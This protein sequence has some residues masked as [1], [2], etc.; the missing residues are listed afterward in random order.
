M[1]TNRIRNRLE[2]IFSL[3]Y[4]FSEWFLRSVFNSSVPYYKRIGLRL[5][6][7]T[8]D[9][10]VICDRRIK[11]LRK[12]RTQMHEAAMF[13]FLMAAAEIG[14]VYNLVED[15]SIS[16]KYSDI[17]VLRQPVGSILARSEWT[18]EERSK[19][20]ASHGTLFKGAALVD[21]SNELCAKAVFE[22]TWKKNV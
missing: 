2:S 1:I 21:E 4:P 15:C 20:D 7:L 10:V 12:N 18:A 14:L 3:P 16:L 11:I 19:M 8:N 9:E 22:F 5:L 17:T 6:K 13:S